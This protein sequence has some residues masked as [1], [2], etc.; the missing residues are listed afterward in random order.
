M[1]IEFH[2]ISISFPIQAKLHFH[3][4]KCAFQIQATLTIKT[5]IGNDAAA[6]QLF[7]ICKLYIFFSKNV[8]TVTQNKQ[9]AITINTN[10]QAD[11]QTNGCVGAR[12]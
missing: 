3:F 8:S 6:V 5:K 12:F 10:K 1:P 2:H 4:I 7:K 9:F 11:R